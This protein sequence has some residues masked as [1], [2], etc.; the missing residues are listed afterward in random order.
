MSGIAW[1]VGGVI[2]IAAEFVYDLDLFGILT[3]PWVM[4]ALGMVAVIKGLVD[5]SR[6]IADMLGRK[7]RRKSVNPSTQLRARESHGQWK[8]WWDARTEAME[9]VLGEMDA[10]VLHAAI[11]FQLGVDLGGAADVVSFSQNLDGIAYVTS[12]LIGMD[13]QAPGE[14]GNYELMICHRTPSD[15]G[16]RVIRLLAHYT[17]DTPLNPGDTMDIGEAT[18]EGSTIVALLFLEY[19]RFRVLG[20]DAGLLLCIGITQE[21]LDV[22]LEKDSSVVEQ[23]LKERDVYPYTD[24]NRQSVFS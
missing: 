12:E 17:L 5:V 22:K 16:P 15:W 8:E 20:R 18:P 7:E 3:G 4:A 11:P 1:I 14:L 6:G 21:E 23:R 24:L 9:A 10:E 13:D 2:L 19:A